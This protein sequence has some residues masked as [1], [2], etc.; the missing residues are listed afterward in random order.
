[1]KPS[2]LRSAVAG[3]VFL[4]A[5]FFPG[6]SPA[7]EMDAGDKLTAAN[8]GG[9]LFITGWGVAN[10]DYGQKSP[11]TGRE[12]WFGQGTDTGG[13]DKLGHAYTTYLLT[14]GM[15]HLCTTWGYADGQAATYGAL[16]SFGLMGFMELGD[17]FSSYGFSHEDFLMNT[18]G[19]CAGYLT[20]R[21]PV[22]SDTLDFRIEYTPAFDEPDILTDYGQMKF[23]AALK[24]SGFHAFHT[25]LWQYLEVHLGYYTR[26]YDD[27]SD[28][29]RYLYGGLGI[30]LSR[31]FQEHNFSTT[32]AILRYVQIPWTDAQLRTSP[33]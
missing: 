27:G 7:W 26:G 25:G 4:L 17:S 2:T 10:W 5:L 12:G 20:T 29:R 24:L 8:A 23:L 9:I 3:L 16:S 21:Y 30:N 28:P 6:V 33:L 18:V 15:A 31:I 14:H 13:A 19:A 11:R 22:V 1:M 32:S